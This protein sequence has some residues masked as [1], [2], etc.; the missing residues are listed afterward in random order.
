MRKFVAVAALV[1][2]ASTSVTAQVTQI[3]IGSRLELFV[4]GY[5]IDSMSGA[6]LELHPPTPAETVFTFDKP[7]EGRYVGYVTVIKDGD[8]HD[9]G[10]YRLYYRGLPV[11]KA[12]GSNAETTCYAESRDGRAFTR[13]S[14]GIFEVEGSR[15]NNVILSEAAPFSHNFAP[16]L[17][18]N[19]AATP[20]QRYKAVAGTESAGLAGFVSPDGIHW[21]K[22]QEKPLI[23]DGKFDS[24]NVAFWSES[25]G[26]YVCYFR[27]WSE[28]GWN[29]YRTVSRSTSPDFVN[30][31][32][33]VQM[34]FGGTPPE[35]L[36]TNQTRPYVR[37]PHIYI[38]TAARFMP[39]RRVISA[40]QAEQIGSEDTYQGDCSDTVF[41]TSRGGNKYDRT[42]MEGFVRPGIGASNWTS[43][44]NYPTY[45]IV[46]T[47]PEE[48]SMYVQRHYG[49]PT[50]HLQRL[51]LRT[52]G[53]VSVNAPYSGGEMITKPVSFSGAR[54]VINYS[55][56]A[57]G[58]IRVELL[59]KDAKA[60][61][62][63]ALEDA[64]TIIG[65]EIE[66]PVSWKGK[67][68]LPQGPLRLRF[69]MKDADLYSIRFL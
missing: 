58:D 33:T 19:P 63:Y 55:T 44:T 61:P 24:Q 41:M 11:A 38:A 28:G 50:H 9:A 10:L 21:Q 57:A 62:G 66:R 43:R 32:P 26:C 60:I 2:L 12:D 14:L 48:L 8:R 68:N 25:E 3:E 13:P 56:S 18:T 47:G 23:T 6:A 53:F 29:G 59:D 69:V 42:F 64:D 15:D 67:T 5:L 51:T 37:A 39:G 30:W 49:Q 45:G 65:D 52:D 7:W 54:L 16:F 17:D 40:E 31:S 1:L 34:D 22:L 46:E 4:D 35:H 20:E 36:Y 27:T